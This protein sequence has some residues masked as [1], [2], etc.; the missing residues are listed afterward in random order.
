MRVDLRTLR[1]ATAEWLHRA[2]LAGKL[3]WVD[4]GRGC[5]SKG[6]GTVPRPAIARSWRGRRRRGRLQNCSWSRRRHGRSR[7]PVVAAR[8]RTQQLPAL[9][10]PAAFPGGQ[11]GTTCLMIGSAVGGQRGALFRTVAPRA[12][13][14]RPCSG[15]AHGS[16]HQ[17]RQECRYLLVHESADGAP[18]AVGRLRGWPGGAMPAHR[19]TPGLEVRL[20]QL[21]RR[22]AGA[23]L[24]RPATH[25]QADCPGRFR[26]DRRYGACKNSPCLLFASRDRNG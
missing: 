5:A 14:C 26:P 17:A 13:R 19:S 7:R 22:H 4:L 24:Q 21:V 1:P 23:P 12:R 15:R 18:P 8:G 10:A 11:R 16:Q 2:L 3:S 20:H 6:T 9:R 25:F